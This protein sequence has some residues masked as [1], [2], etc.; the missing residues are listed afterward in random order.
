MEERNVHSVAAEV[1]EG[2]RTVDS[3]AVVEDEG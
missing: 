3:V 1:V 2:G